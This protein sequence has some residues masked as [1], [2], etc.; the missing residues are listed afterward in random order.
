MTEIFNRVEVK[1]KRQ[2]LRNEMTP[3]EVL[4]WARLRRKQVMG[5][6]FRRQYSVGP[7]IL[8]FYCP[9]LKLAVEIDGDSHLGEEAQAYDRE[10]QSS[11][12]ALGIQFLRFTNGEVFENMEGVMETVRETVTGLRPPA[13]PLGKGDRWA[14]RCQT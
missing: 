2:D 6:R 7:Y 4:A 14:R 8:D 3:A 13:V 10:R 11:I 1:E 9:S 12:E 5:Y